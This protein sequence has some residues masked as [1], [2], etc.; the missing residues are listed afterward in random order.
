MLSVETTWDA[1]KWKTYSGYFPYKA[2]N[3]KQQDVKKRERI[4]LGIS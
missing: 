1:R 3:E 4:S 2:L